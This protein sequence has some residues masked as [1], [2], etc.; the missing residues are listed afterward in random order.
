MIT[1]KGNYCE[2]LSDS[3]SC[4]FAWCLSCRRNLFWNSHPGTRP[5]CCLKRLPVQSMVCDSHLDYV[6]HPGCALFDSSLSPVHSNNITRSYWGA[7][8]HQWRNIC[9]CHG[10]LLPASRDGR[11]TNPWTQHCCYISHT[12]SAPFYVGGIGIECYWH[13]CHVNYLVS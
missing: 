2:T 6:W 7:C 5:G 13:D 4:F 8:G 9:D 12:L 3:S 11:I 10:C 1:I